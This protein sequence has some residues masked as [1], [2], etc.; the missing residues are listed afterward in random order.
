RRLFNSKSRAFS[1]GCIR[2]EKA[3]ELAHI[4]VTGAPGRESKYISKFLKE[5]TQHWVDLTKPIPIHIRYFTCAFTGNALRFHDDVYGKDEAL[6]QML[7]SSRH[8]P[9]L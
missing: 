6:Y 5:K 7:H 3:I 8:L 4:L 9:D 2:M 1:H